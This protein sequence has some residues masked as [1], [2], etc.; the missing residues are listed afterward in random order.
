MLLRVKVRE[1]QRRSSGYGDLEGLSYPDKCVRRLVG[2]RH[3]VGEG[4]WAI[5][6]V[7]NVLRFG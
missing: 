4:I 6:I 3:S 1:G 5:G 2:P 7:K